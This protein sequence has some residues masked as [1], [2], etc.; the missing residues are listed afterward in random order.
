MDKGR[1]WRWLVVLALAG[2]G[3]RAAGDVLSGGS[4]GSSEGSSGKNNP[5]GGSGEM[6]L[7][8]QPRVDALV[9]LTG[10]Q[11][12]PSNLANPDAR[13]SDQDFDANQLFTLLPSLQMQPGYQLDYVYHFDGLGGFPYLYARPESQPRFVTEAE[14]TRTLSTQPVG[15]PYLEHVQG[16]GSPQSFL[17]LALLVRL[18]ERF[19]IYWHA[20]YGDAAVVCDPKVLK[21]LVASLANPEIGKPM[22]KEDQALARKLDPAPVVRLDPD[23]VTVELLTF[24]I[25]T[26]FDRQVLVFRREPPHTLL[27]STRQNLVPYNAGIVY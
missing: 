5:G 26:G 13:R 3:C 6:P 20:G 24:S 12:L 21:D 15:A 17:D 7:V 8:C 14:Y 2:L 1:M 23:K 19:Y 27:E 9:Q 16:D 11:Q 10:A 4:S 25:F 22:P 18:G